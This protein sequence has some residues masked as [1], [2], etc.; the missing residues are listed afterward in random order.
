MR[1]AE[2]QDDMK[3][4]DEEM[5]NRMRSLS[6]VAL[7]CLCLAAA[8]LSAQQVAPVS[9]AQANAPDT[10][11]LAL[12]RQRWGFFLDFVGKPLIMIDADAGRFAQEFKLKFDWEI[13][14]EVMTYTAFGNNGGVAP[15]ERFQWDEANRRIVAPRPEG[16][17]YL[18]TQESGDV[19]GELR[20]ADGVSRVTYALEGGAIS[21][22][23]ESNVG[24]GWVPMGYTLVE[25]AAES[26]IA[27][28]PQRAKLLAQIYQARKISADVMA[29]MQGSMS[30]AEF[31]VYL[32][33]LEEK[34]RQYE[35]AKRQKKRERSERWDKVMGAVSTGLSVAADAY[36]QASAE[37]AAQQAQQQAFLDSLQQQAKQA[38]RARGI[39]QRVAAG[40]G[41]SSGGNLLMEDK[42]KPTPAPVPTQPTPTP[43][44]YGYC[45]HTTIGD[46][47]DSG[48]LPR[49]FI[50]PVVRM[51]WLRIGG[52]GNDTLEQGFNAELVSQYG[53][54]PNSG[55]SCSWYDS[56][57]LAEQRR[58]EHLDDTGLFRIVET[59]IS[60]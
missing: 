41:S 42:P 26:T 55:S 7:A 18:S 11:T 47:V 52:A 20:L 31:K 16:N 38:E 44:R 56:P 19:V 12:W 17:L 34:N 53:L 30:D 1:V 14:G 46:P 5:W 13:P 49:K 54:H 22:F 40:N 27:T 29:K 10:K 35:E 48:K 39:Q 60:P 59:S 28:A 51:P 25:E 50:S 3:Q 37:N 8:P 21:A 6:W 58:G 23:S 24:N 9:T 43:D 15:L 57:Q 45:L 32:A 36:A 4:G 2:R 33:Q